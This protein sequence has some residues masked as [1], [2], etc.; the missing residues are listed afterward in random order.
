MAC[1]LSRRW[2]DPAGAD[3]IEEKM[4]DSKRQSAEEYSYYLSKDSFPIDYEPLY[5]Q[6]GLELRSVFQTVVLLPFDFPMKDNQSVSLPIKDNRIFTVNF[7]EAERKSTTFLGLE[8]VQ[9]QETQKSHTLAEI[10][11]FSTK[12]SFEY[13]ETMVSSDFDEAI[14]SLN[15]VLSAYRSLYRDANIP[16]FRTEMIATTCPFGYYSIPEWKPITKA[17]TFDYNPQS[18][19][20][21]LSDL[22]VRRYL[23]YLSIFRD[24]SNPFPLLEEYLVDAH[25]HLLNGQF[26]WSVISAQTHIEGLL[27]IIYKNVRQFEGVAASQ[28][29]QDLEDLSFSNL[30][31]VEMPK[32]VGGNWNL[33]QGSGK[34]LRWYNDCYQLRN[35]IVHAGHRV[36]AEEAKRAYIA[37]EEMKV[38]VHLQLRKNEK[39]RGA[40]SGQLKMG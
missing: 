19:K 25:G 1:R 31:K 40:F 2:A 36:G 39:I 28:V 22:E 7:R 34:V 30:V 15:I 24:R 4:E 20:A 23:D 11:L 12:E 18:K 27:R 26:E 17:G 5:R 16:R 29:E 8:V 38:F 6:F 37:A 14:D 13:Q 35:R 33:Y 9:I 32:I 10:G 21:R 3:I